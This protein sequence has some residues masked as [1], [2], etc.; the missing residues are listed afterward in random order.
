MDY[1]VT[2]LPFSNV[3]FH[4]YWLVK[5]PR[6]LRDDCNSLSKFI[7]GWELLSN[8]YVFGNNNNGREGFNR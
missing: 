5:S 7:V 6:D 3:V 4:Y 1:S 8:F 2:N